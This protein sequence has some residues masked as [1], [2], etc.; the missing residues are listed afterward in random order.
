[1]S[2]KTSTIDTVKLSPRLFEDDSLMG[3]ISG[4]FACFL[5]ICTNLSKN[6]AVDI[7]AR[8]VGV[9]EWHMTDEMFRHACSTMV[10]SGANLENR[11]SGVRTL[12]QEE[13]NS[14]YRVGLLHELPTEVLGCFELTSEEMWAIKMLRSNKLDWRD[15]SNKLMKKGLMKSVDVACCAFMAHQQ[16][17]LWDNA[18]SAP[19]ENLH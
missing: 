19:A 4:V 13:R 10:W 6:E 16:A 3:P 1:M 17:E 14:A 2:T 12:S 8:L 7:T 15:D 5:T 11:Y 18:P 9:E